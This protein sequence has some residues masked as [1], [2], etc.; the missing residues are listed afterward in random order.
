M[1]VQWQN[2]PVTLGHQ[3]FVHRRI[4][5]DNV[6]FT[7]LRVSAQGPEA[8]PKKMIRW[9][10]SLIR[11]REIVEP[12]SFVDPVL[13]EFSFDQSLGWKKN[14]M[15]GTVDAELVLGSN[16]EAPPNEMLETAR[17][18]VADWIL[19]FPKIREYIRSELGNW[20]IEPNLPSPDDFEV[21]SINFLWKQKPTTSMI[22]FHVPDDEFRMWHVTFEGFEPKGLAYDD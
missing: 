15:L 8:H 7:A 12:S 3:E 20:I 11:K 9:L 4:E 1:V 22:F 21:E 6:T 5:S 17:S 19:E 10:R 13:G 14:I 18:W 16:G 2:I